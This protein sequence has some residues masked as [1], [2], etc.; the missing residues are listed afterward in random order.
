MHPCQ[1]IQRLKEA[2]QDVELERWKLVA[3]KVGNGSSASACQRK[4]E[5]L[6][7][8]VPERPGSLTSPP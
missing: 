7:L 6:D 4:A 3:N 1:Q 2:I 5:E 8:V